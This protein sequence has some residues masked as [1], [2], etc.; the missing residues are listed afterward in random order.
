MK[1]FNVLWIDDDPSES[2]LNEAYEYGL[3]IDVKTCHNDGIA[4]LKNPNNSYDA[5]ILDANCKIT[6]EESEKPSLDSLTESILEVH[7]YCT[8]S[9]LIPWFVYTG[10]G[11]E[12]FDNL[13][14]RISSKR[15]WDDRKYYKKPIQRYELFDNLK[16]AIE[17]INSPEWQ[18]RNEY[19]DVFE[20]CSDK[21]IG[22]QNAGRLLKLLLSLKNKDNQNPIHFNSIRKVTEDIF[23]KLH[24]IGILPREQD[25]NGKIE[26]ISFN[27]KSRFLSNLSIIPIYI[28]RN[29]HSVISITQDASHSKNNPGNEMKSTNLQVD[30][31]IQSNKAPYLLHSTIYELLNILSWSKSFIDDNSK[32]ESNKT[33]IDLSP[34]KIIDISKIKDTTL[35]VKNEISNSI[36]ELE[37]IITKETLIGV[38]TSL[39]PSGGFVSLEN[40]EIISMDSKLI[41][42][43][44]NLK[45]NDNINATIEIIQGKKTITNL[46]V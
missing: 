7:F 28:Q 32:V 41:S 34:K 13:E 35:V 37:P 40:G 26:K 1:R 24:Q 19:S 6:N 43:Y 2:F 15:L 29:I 36:I 31:D 9:Q 4:A 39:L 5:I 45:V 20:V 18:I 23:E 10:G 21:Y 16:K 27:G 22:G 11:Y 17:A 8:A 38:I 33:K 30:V 12:G 14:S 44:K 25:N 3:D 42:K 46:E